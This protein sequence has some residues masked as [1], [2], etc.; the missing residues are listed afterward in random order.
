[1]KQRKP[2][3]YTF[4]EV[5][6]ASA[7]VGAVIGGAV[8]LAGTANLQSEAAR[9]TSLAL[10]YQDN[11]ARLWQLGLTPSEVVAL[12]PDVTNNSDLEAA[13]VPYGSAPGAQVSFTSA[14]TFTLGSSM[15]SLED[16]T[17]SVTIRNPTGGAD[18]A[19][20]V[21]IYRPTIR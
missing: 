8:S 11:A 13:I 5:L 4:V 21:E 17:C 12:L 6:V 9:S 10:N 19:V 7:L 18:R 16:I 2:H 20:P 1:M 15:G 3:G 14:G